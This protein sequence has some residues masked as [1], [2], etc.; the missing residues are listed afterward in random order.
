MQDTVLMG[1]GCWGG[2][3]RHLRG[4]SLVQ[5]LRG[6][7]GFSVQE[8]RGEGLRAAL[9]G[10]AL[11]NG[12]CLHSMGRQW[13]CGRELHG[14]PALEQ[15]LLKMGKWTGQGV[16]LRGSLDAHVQSGLLGSDTFLALDSSF[17]G[18]YFLLEKECWSQP[19]MLE[20]LGS[21]SLYSHLTECSIR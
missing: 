3:G 9:Y 6:Q 18:K 1:S 7:A 12:T 21:F 11:Q 20:H 13:R 15:G 16:T 2:S 5:E 4:S 19:L 17:W 10:S 8:C 14:P